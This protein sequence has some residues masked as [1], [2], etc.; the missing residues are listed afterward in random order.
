MCNLILGTDFRKNTLSYKFVDY[1]RNNKIYSTKSYFRKYFT[2]NYEIKYYH[3]F[4][5]IR[6][7]KVSFDSKCE[8]HSLYFN[9]NKLTYYPDLQKI[10]LIDLRLKA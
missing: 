5:K 4:W 6:K 8:V 2:I 10:G 1:H 7:K 9:R 3:L